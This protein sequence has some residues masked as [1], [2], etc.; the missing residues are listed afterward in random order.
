MSFPQPITSKDQEVTMVTIQ[1]RTEEESQPSGLCSFSPSCCVSLFPKPTHCPLGVP[2][3]ALQ[4]C[5]RPPPNLL[6]APPDSRHPRV[7]TQPPSAPWNVLCPPSLLL[8]WHLGEGHI[9]SWI[10][11]SLGA[12]LW[13][14]HSLVY[15]SENH[16][17]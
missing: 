17:P 14:S 2:L 3:V 5:A 1:G 7:F 4:S 6:S 15:F 9:S 8:I 12:C 16:K 11:R 10:L 13:F